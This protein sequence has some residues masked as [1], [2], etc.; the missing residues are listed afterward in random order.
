MMDQ[1][2]SFLWY[3]NNQ[4]YFHGL[5]RS[6]RECMELNQFTS[7]DYGSVSISNHGLIKS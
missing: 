3:T 1:I 7:L 5:T 2:S 4:I 6:I